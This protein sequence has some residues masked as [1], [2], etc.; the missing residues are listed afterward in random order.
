M[1]DFASWFTLDLY[2][3]NF[4]TVLLRLFLAAVI[5]GIIGM[6]RERQNQTA[7]LRTHMLIC[8]GAAVAALT[9]D[10]IAQYVSPG[11]DASRM[12]AQVIS[13]VGFLGAGTIIVGR[14]KIK[15][16]TTA[17]GI[18]ATACVGLAAGIGFYA[19]ALAG[20]LLITIILMALRKLDV[21]IRTRNKIVYLYLEV[22][23][24]Q[25]F[26]AVHDLIEQ[27]DMKISG[28]EC[29]R[30][31]SGEGHIM[32]IDLKLKQGKRREQIALIAAIAELDGVL[33]VKRL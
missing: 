2:Q 29:S 19:G 5:G 3:L 15:G 1:P 31:R 9:N 14:Q 4:L 21:V 30:V 13:G 22:S 32:S 6:D 12:A 23:S 11:S 26:A 33:F 24:M 18:W 17:A 10:Y 27:S 28:I 16:L 8:L 25:H 20:G 7:G